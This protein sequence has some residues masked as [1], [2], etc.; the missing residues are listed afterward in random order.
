LHYSNN[1]AKIS[2]LQQHRRAMEV[3]VCEQR[4]E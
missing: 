2:A 1:W 3:E 4:H